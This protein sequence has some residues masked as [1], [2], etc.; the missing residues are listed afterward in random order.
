V[1]ASAPAL[2]GH[3]YPRHPWIVAIS[4]LSATFM[5]VLDTTVVSVALPHMAGSLSATNEEATWTLTSYLVANAVVLPMT[6]WLARRVG[7]KN[8]LLASVAGF[9]A[10][11]LLCGLATS[12]PVLVLARV[13]QGLSGGPLQPLS[14]AVMLESF[15][16]GE[17][18]RAMGFWA[19]GI[20]VAPMLGPIVGGWITDHWSWHWVFFINI[21][22]G[23]LALAM[24]GWNVADPVYLRRDRDRVDVGGLVLLV[25]G[26]GALQIVLDK[27]QQ[28][29]WFSSKAITA[30]AILSAVTLAALVVRELRARDPILDLRVF[31]ERTFATGVL[32]MTCVGLVLYGSLT[33]L[34]LLLQ[35]LLGYSAYDA[36]IAV[37]PRGFGSFLAMPVIGLIVG[38]Y[39]TRRLLFAGLTGCALMLFWLAKLNLDAG[40]WDWFWPQ[41]VMGICLALIFV[42]LT[43]ITM[44]PIPRESMG[45]A[46]SLFNLMR[47]I[48]GSIGIA[49]SATLVERKQQ[50]FTHLIGAHVTPYDP[51]SREALAAAGRQFLAAGADPATAARAA[52]VSLFGRVLR[53]AALLGYLDTF[54]ILG[55]I[56]LLILPL[57]VLMRSPVKRG[58]LSALH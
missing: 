47:N 5:E 34:P 32:L 20:V 22:V 48:G 50:A 30:L 4:V 27:G 14:Q 58:G 12:L 36:G 46:T 37:A 40:Y 7:R 23:A 57:V 15:P 35:T 3:E 42:P 10:S 9:T 49:L 2:P 25:V 39:A 53:E 51:V 38:R 8:L 31:R 26:I 1:S 45:N 28:E 33:L 44:D 56:F 13:L 16:P 55:A 18:G 6:G 52:E 19:L 41:F 54:R 21:P 24:I 29:D 11:S 17:R 43:T